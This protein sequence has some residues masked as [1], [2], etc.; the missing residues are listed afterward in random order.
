MRI[1]KMFLQ[2]LGLLR[3]ATAQDAAD[4]GICYTRNNARDA[5]RHT[6]KANLRKVLVAAQR[7][8]R[9]RPRRVLE[10]RTGHRQRR[11]DGAATPGGVAPPAPCYGGLQGDVLLAYRAKGSS[12]VELWCGNEILVA[13]RAR[14]PRLLL[15]S[16]SP[17][18]TAC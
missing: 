18:C 1:R 10:A 2:L 7:V 9:Q 13:G 15:P 3:A 5:N 14:V 16:S 11:R 4:I 8:R 17:L 12:Q 6:V